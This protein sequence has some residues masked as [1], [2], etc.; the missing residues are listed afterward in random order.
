MLTIANLWIPLLKVVH[1]RL[2]VLEKAVERNHPR[3]TQ[4]IPQI[5]EITFLQSKWKENTYEHS[6]FSILT[7]TTRDTSVNPQ[8]ADVGNP[9]IIPFD[10]DSYPILIDNCCTACVTNEMNDFEGTLQRFKPG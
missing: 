7:A 5:R 3:I 2:I 1:Q 9:K 10:S 4:S 6:L 8:S